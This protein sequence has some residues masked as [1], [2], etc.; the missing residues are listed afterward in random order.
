MDDT[1]LRAFLAEHALPARAEGT[2]TPTSLPKKRGARALV[3]RNIEPAPEATNG[4]DSRL[5]SAHLAACKQAVQSFDSV[6]LGRAL[7]RAK[8]R[9]S[10]RA[11]IDGVIAPLLVWVGERWSEGSICVAQEHLAS[12]VVRSTLIAEVTAGAA[13]SEAPRVVVTTPVLELHE[14]GA[15][16]AA[17]AATSAGWRVEYLG[18]NLPAA[19]IA[20][21]ARRCG[22]R[23]VALS[24]A[25]P[26]KGANVV[27]EMKE[28]RRLLPKKTAIFVGGRGAAAYRET[29]E[30]IG[31]IGFD[32]CWS[33]ARHLESQGSKWK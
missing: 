7:A 22:A 30:A 15:M 13:D 28:L 14:L 23:A 25:R 16:L 12:A 18:P 20:V 27:A 8:V 2:V 24:L 21:A 1:A 19:E 5:E 26:V 29:L 6:A 31:T 9:L 3:A 10:L 32:D 4:A 17:L 11:L 33:F